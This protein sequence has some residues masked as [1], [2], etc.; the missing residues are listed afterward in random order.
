M[1]EEEF[2]DLIRR[3]RDPTEIKQEEAGIKCRRWA[4]RFRNSFEGNRQLSN[5]VL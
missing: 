2:T 4:S 5:R 3:Q 1:R